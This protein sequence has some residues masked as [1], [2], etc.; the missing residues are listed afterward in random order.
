M[1]EDAGHLAGAE[2][3]AS[4]NAAASAMKDQEKLGASQVPH[5]P[6]S[7]RAGAQDSWV[8]PQ[9]D[10]S[11][12]FTGMEAEMLAGSR[13]RRVSGRRATGGAG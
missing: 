10:P 8:A 4:R 6:S 11:A 9:M 5:R 3:E 13:S 2:L 7:A 1:G 12:K